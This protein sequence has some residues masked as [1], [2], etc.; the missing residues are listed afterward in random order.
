KM[1]K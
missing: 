1:A